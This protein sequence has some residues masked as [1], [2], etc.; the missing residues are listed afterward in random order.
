MQAFLDEGFGFGVEAGGGF[1]EDQNS[2]VGQDGA[3]DGDALALA[4]GK[5]DAAFADDGVVFVFEIL[6]EFVDAG[7]AAGFEDLFFGGAGAGEGDVFFDAAIEEEGV[8]QDH[9]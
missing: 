1:V 7:D 9:A 5:F 3:G 6:G 2:R 4:A 8:L